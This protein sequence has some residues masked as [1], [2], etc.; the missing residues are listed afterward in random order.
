MSLFRSAFNE[1]RQLR[2]R[3]R[4]AHTY[5]QFQNFTMISADAFADN[6]VLADRVRNVS[7]CI[8]EC[9]VW[10]GGMSAGLASMFG[11]G[12]EYFLFDSFEGLPPAREID[13]RAALKWQQDVDAPNYFDNC[14]ASVEFALEAM[15]RT[16]AKAFHLVEGWFEHTLPNF[17][18]PSPIALLR[19]DADWYES[20]MVCLKHLFDHLAPGGLLLLDDYYQ[21]DG[22]SRALHDFLSHRCAVE[23]IRNLN[24]LCYLQKR[25][26]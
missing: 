12:R 8:V 22:C 18:P 9:G 1:I 26:S 19:L 14:S 16:E 11:A 10:R 15:G 3:R 4:F 6:L 17:R 2:K 24:N 21:W 13:G 7:G 5:K 25:A 20:T 23:R